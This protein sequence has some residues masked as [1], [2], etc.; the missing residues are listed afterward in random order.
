MA[1]QLSILAAT[2]LNSSDE[3]PKIRS[4]FHN[5]ISSAPS[6]LA[7]LEILD[8][9]HVTSSSVKLRSTV[10]GTYLYSLKALHVQ[11]SKGGDSHVWVILL[12]KLCNQSPGFHALVIQEET[13][14][15]LHFGCPTD[16]LTHL[17]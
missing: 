15:P 6:A 4:Q 1:I 8:A 3:H 10:L 13:P 12:E 17:T 14:S 9:T 2:T 7:V 11:F 16:I 5:S